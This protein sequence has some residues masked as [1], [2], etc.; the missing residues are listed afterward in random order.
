MNHF[1]YRRGALFAEDVPLARIAEQV[2]TP[3]Y[4]Y[5][6]ATLTRHFRVLTSTFAG[7]PHLL[8]YS[9]K[10]NSNL[11]I[12][13]LFAKLGSGFDIVT[14]GELERVLQAGGDPRKVVFSG[15]GKT[16]TEMARAL[17]AGILM[18]N[19]ESAEELEALDR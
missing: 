6:T 19:L 11:S 15:V 10:A 8:C 13:R 1:H 9:V 14:Q 2:G 7:Q 4:V 12:L 5:S 17:R 18:F 3:T 16:D